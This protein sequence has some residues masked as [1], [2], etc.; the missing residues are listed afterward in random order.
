M[1]V[2][3]VTCVKNE[4]AFVL[5][6]IAHHKAVGFTDFLVFSNDCTDGTDLML[7]RLQRMGVVTHLRND[8][9]YGQGGVQWTGFKIADKH[10]VVQNADWLMTLDVDE[11]VNIH[12]GDHTLDALLTALPDADAITMT[13]R[14]FGNNGVVDY[15]DRPITDQFTRAAPEVM[16]W[17]WRAFMFKTLYRNAG[18]YEKLGVHRPRAPVDGTVEATRWFDGHGRALDKSFQRGRIFSPFDRPNYGLVQLNHYPLGAMESFVLKCDRGR[19]NRSGRPI[20]MGYWCDRNWSEVEDLTIRQTR[21][22]RAQILAQLMADPTLAALHNKAVTW[23]RAR[24]HDLMQD[25]GNRALFG[26]LMMTPPAHPLLTTQAHKIYKY[27]QA[28]RNRAD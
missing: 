10:P 9:P 17:P 25:E 19:V 24:F 23:R 1:R 18:A 20:D 5:E 13:W 14:L 26:R 3:A 21:D 8:G 6:W 7:D 11:F 2:T 12:T 15:L 4:A 16:T 28:T 22:P 27:A